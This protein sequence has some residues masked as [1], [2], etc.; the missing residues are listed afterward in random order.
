MMGKK[1]FWN[2]TR[3]ATDALWIAASIDSQKKKIM[4]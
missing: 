3:F 2:S 1:Q 4:V